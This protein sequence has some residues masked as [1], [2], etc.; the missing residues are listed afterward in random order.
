MFL[1]GYVVCTQGDTGRNAN[2]TQKG[3]NFLTYHSRTHT[4]T[5][6]E[7]DAWLLEK[8]AFF[9]QTVS[10]TWCKCGANGCNVSINS[11]VPVAAYIQTTLASSSV[12][13]RPHWLFIHIS[14]SVFFTAAQGPKTQ[15]V[16]HL[17]N[18]AIRHLKYQGKNKYFIRFPF[19]CVLP[20]C[21]YLITICRY[22]WVLLV[23]YA[24]GVIKKY[25]PNMHPLR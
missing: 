11:G 14:Y 18:D 23:I 19:Y 9:S 8:Q 1:W 4:Q 17:G 5:H 6:R 13:T 7:T 21:R 16:I 22:T 25:I 10:L 3:S 12:L 20:L 15:L 2:S 24:E